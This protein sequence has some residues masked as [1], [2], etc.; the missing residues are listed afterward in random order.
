M[1][2]ITQRDVDI[3][4]KMAEIYNTEVDFKATCWFWGEFK[5]K[6]FE[7]FREKYPEG[8]LGF[9]Y[10]EKFTS[11]FDLAGTLASKGLLNEDLYY[12]KYGTEWAEWQK[13]GPII[14]GLRKEWNEPSY[15]KNFEWLVQEGEK[16]RK[17]KQKQK[18]K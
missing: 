5:E 18:K 14:H 13:A 1:A 7:E 10:F 4:L 15:R 11:K 16:W 8:S 2:K 6:T 17:K 3:F 12:E 9:Q